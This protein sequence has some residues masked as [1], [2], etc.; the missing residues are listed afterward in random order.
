M[1]EFKVMPKEKKSRPAKGFNK[2][3]NI[4]AF[5]ESDSDSYGSESGMNAR[6][7]FVKKRGGKKRTKHTGGAA[8]D[9]ESQAT[10]NYNSGDDL[11]S[12]VDDI[13]VATFTG[14]NYM[15]EKIEMD[16]DLAP[17][18][19]NIPDLSPEKENESNSTNINPIEK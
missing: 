10:F 1:P 15:D 3:K 19:V 2:I 9:I 16:K 4:Q 14:E 17:E 12:I 13:S 11:V 5:I 7:V 18:I 8:M 6:I